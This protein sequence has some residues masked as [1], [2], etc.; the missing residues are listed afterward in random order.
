MIKQ[1]LLFFLFTLSYTV[2]SQIIMGNA[3]GTVPPGQ[4]SSVLLEFAA[5]QNKGIILPYLRTLPTSTA[6]SPGTLAVD[7]VNPTQAKVVYYNGT[8][9]IDLSSGDRADLSSELAVQPTAVTE[10]S[11]A[12]TI[13]GASESSA[14]GVLILES[15][16]KA[17]VLP[18][19]QNTDEVPDPAPGMMVYINTEGAKRLA[20]YNGNSWTYWKASTETV[21][22]VTSST[23]RIWMDRNLGATRVATSL[24][25][26]AAYGDVYQ[27]GRRSDGHQLRNATTTTQQS[28]TDTPAHSSFI[29]GSASDWRNP[30]N[31]N[32]WQGVTG[33]NNPCPTGFR[34][35]TDAEWSAEISTFNPPNASGAFASPLKLVMNG[36][37]EYYSGS[38]YDYDDFGV[39]WTASTSG[40]YSKYIALNS[41]GID[42]GYD[43]ERA[44]GFAVRCI[45]D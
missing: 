18:T 43:A 30:P 10:K 38:I 26:T 5:G 31:N 4:K 21:P 17:M 35:P 20:V 39:Y 8:A 9:W 37:R 16:T 45:K 23:G 25:D 7:A 14:D 29:I 32:L 12:R 34:L 27:W 22:T 42:S 3:A 33:I 40:S 24:S 2:S 28:N 15:K 1:I 36:Y 41:W 6:L 11:A 19:V 13:L 44:Y